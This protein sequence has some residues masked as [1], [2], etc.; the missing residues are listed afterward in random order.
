LR[1]AEVIKKL[2]IMKLEYRPHTPRLKI[3]EQYI[4][5]EKGKQK[6][7]KKLLEKIEKFEK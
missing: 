4:L 5:R 3:V 1:Q 7:L 2:R 6:N